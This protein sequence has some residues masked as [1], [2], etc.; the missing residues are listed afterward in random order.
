MAG[1]NSEEVTGNQV[2]AEALKLQVSILQN[3][4]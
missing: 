4:S 1:D 2:V 3:N